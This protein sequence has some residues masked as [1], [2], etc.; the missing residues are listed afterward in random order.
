VVG[1]MVAAGTVVTGT[2][3]LAGAASVARYHLK[4][5]AV[6]QLHADIGWLLGGLVIAMALALRL[7][8][9]PRPAARLGWLLVALV[10]VQGVIG[11]VQ[12]FSGLPAGLVWFHVAGAILIWITALRLTFATRERGNAAAPALPV[13]ELARPAATG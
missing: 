3:P 4:L 1:L 5:A 10:G 6:T 13:P 9:A 8:S 12:Y 11:Y 7:T 2:G